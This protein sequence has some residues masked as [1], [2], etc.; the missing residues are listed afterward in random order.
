MVIRGHPGSPRP[1]VAE[2]CE[3]VDAHRSRRMLASAVALAGECS[4]SVV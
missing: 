3:E 4:I 2:A 1:R